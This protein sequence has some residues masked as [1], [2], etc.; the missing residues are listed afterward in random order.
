MSK[1]TLILSLV[2]ALVSVNCNTDSTGKAS[3]SSASSV[4]FDADA[5]AEV[6]ER[7]EVH[8]EQ[9]ATDGDVE[10]VFDLLGGDEGLLKLQVVGPDGRMLVDFT[11]PDATTLGVR[12][13][14]MESPEPQDISALKKAYP[15]GIYKFAATD[16][17]GTGFRSEA[18]LSHTLPQPVEFLNP[19]E[20]AEDVS[21]SE[22]KITWSAVE[23][24]AMYIVE[25]EIEDEVLK[26]NV[27][28]KLPEPVTSFSV[29]DNF[30]R[31]GS[32]YKISIGTV[33]KEGN[34][35]FVETAFRTEGEGEHN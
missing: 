12:S 24:V 21:V 1:Q 26:D 23:G 28:A 22:L 27:L 15:E 6:F 19:K 9:N 30:L 34:I 29:P 4:S 25:V 33:S 13:F 32:E 2:I 14:R 7:A 8:F 16:A 20:E 11:A 18:T 5:K 17:A 10:V 35:S 31:P 3:E